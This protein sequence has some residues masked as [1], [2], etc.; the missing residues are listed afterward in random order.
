MVFGTK[1]CLQLVDKRAHQQMVQAFMDDIPNQA[2]SS[3]LPPLDQ[4]ERETL[5]KLLPYLHCFQMFKANNSTAH[6]APP[7]EKITP[8]PSIAIHGP[9]S[10]N[11][12]VESHTRHSESES[13][14]ISHESSIHFAKLPLSA[15]NT[16]TASESSLQQLF[17]NSFAELKVDINDLKEDVSTLKDKVDALQTNVNDKSHSLLKAITTSVS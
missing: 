12:G 3:Q 11:D 10:A 1:S 14:N 17:K 2:L 9:L 5:Q 4:S 7:L 15:T 8:T 6:D 16:F 13:D